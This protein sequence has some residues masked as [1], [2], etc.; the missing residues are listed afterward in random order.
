M[1]NNITI[2]IYLFLVFLT[3]IAII[4]AFYSNEM[5]GVV[6][7]D[8]NYDLFQNRLSQE[9]RQSIC[10]VAESFGKVSFI[11]LIITNIVGVIFAG[12]LIL[13]RVRADAKKTI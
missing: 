11:P 4:F 2:V 7:Y 1:K 13:S 12:F 8:A 10:Y 9:Q 6:L 3:I 5:T